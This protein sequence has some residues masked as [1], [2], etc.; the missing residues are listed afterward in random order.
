MIQ[1]GALNRKDIEIL[2]ERIEVDG[3]G[4]P[5]IELKYGLS[6]LV[7]YSP[8]E[9]LNR[10]ENEI[11]LAAMRLIRDDGRNFISAKYLSKRLTDVGCPKSTKTVL[12]Y[13]AMLIEIGVAE[14]CENK[15]KPYTIVKSRAELEKMIADF[16][17]SHGGISP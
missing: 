15:R 4:L 14:P 16:R 9:D 10:H 5:E 8:A 12:P 2:I 3:E 17:E 6:G 11:I 7:P 13:I 1:K